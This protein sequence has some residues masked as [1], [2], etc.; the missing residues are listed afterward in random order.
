MIHLYCSRP[1]SLFSVSVSYRNLGESFRH[2]LK[3]IV[4]FILFIDLRVPQLTWSL[5]AALKKP[6][7]HFHHRWFASYF[8][9]NNPLSR[10]VTLSCSCTRV[11]TRFAL[12]NWSNFRLVK[13]QTVGMSFI[14]FQSFLCCLFKL[15]KW[16][17]LH[18]HLFIFF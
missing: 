9:V 8:H 3:S 6:C 1:C 12:T 14:Y 2:S 5:T 15:W 11:H 13:L 10:Q 16:I 18:I 4:G 7:L 17:S